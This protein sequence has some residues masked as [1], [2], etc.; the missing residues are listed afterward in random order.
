MGKSLD[1]YMQTIY[2]WAIVVAEIRLTEGNM[3]EMFIKWQPANKNTKAMLGHILSVVQEYT[4]QGYQLTLRQ[5]Y[6]QLVARDII[7]N[8]QAHYKRTG[9]IVAKARM[10]GWLDWNAI[11]DRGRVP[12]LPSYWDSPADILESAARGYRIDRWQ[13]QQ[14]YVEVWVEKD[15]LMGVL[16]PICSRNHVR[17]LACRGYTSATAMYDSAKRLEAAYANGKD[18]HILYLGDHDPSGLDMTR[19]IDKRLY[20]MSHADVRVNRLALNMDQVLDH[21][22]PPNPA[23]LS[24]SRA[25]GYIRE[26]GYESWELDALDPGTLAA[27]VE[28]AIEELRDAEQWDE[29]LKREDKERQQIIEVAANLSK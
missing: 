1:K 4:A 13:G 3:R 2:I 7:P 11:V 25:T 15:A 17:A 9:D 28:G 12:V 24:D 21:Q 10:G 6:Y 22:P 29:M 23:K 26:Y 8:S 5:L 20:L 18:T 19:D 14:A 16:E 27:I